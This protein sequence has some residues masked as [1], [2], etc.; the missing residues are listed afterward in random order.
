[1]CVS[2]PEV[3]FVHKIGRRGQGASG[4]LLFPIG[5][6]TSEDRV[7]V[8]DNGNDCVKMF[9][10]TGQHKATIGVRHRSSIIF[11]LRYTIFV[12]V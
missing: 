8:G 12:R 10:F 1:M 2:A 3:T 7:I 6:T 9:D 5:V 4:T 11:L